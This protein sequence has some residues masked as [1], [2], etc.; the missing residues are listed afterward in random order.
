MKWQKAHSPSFPSLHLR[1]SSSSNPSLALPN[2]LCS[3]SKHS[4]TSPTSQLIL[5]LQA[6][7]HF[8]Y[9]TVHS[10]PFPRFTYNSFSNPPLLHLRHSWFS[11]LSVALPTSQLIFQPFRCFTY[12][13]AHSLTL[14]SLL[15]RHRLFLTSPGKPP[16][17]QSAK[18][19]FLLELTDHKDRIWKANVKQIWYCWTSRR[20]LLLF[21]CSWVLWYI[22]KSQVISIAF[23]IERE[24]PTNF[25]QMLYFQVEVLLHAVNLRHR[26]NGFTSLPKEVILSILMLWKKSI[27][28]SLFWTCKPRIQWRVW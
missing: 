24:N 28:P 21:C 25:A 20:M 8:I 14:L 18:A 6:F 1:H 27:D 4:V 23:Y 7:C 22:L 19:P 3:F 11:N 10:H 17:Q 5:I 15:L 2:E 13:T 9:V 16:M 26:T 12:I